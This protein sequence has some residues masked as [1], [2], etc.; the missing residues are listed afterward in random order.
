MPVDATLNSSSLL[1]FRS[2]IV[3]KAV[4]NKFGPQAPFTALGPLPSHSTFMPRIASVTISLIAIGGDRGA[5]LS[6]ASL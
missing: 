2:T 4:W 1:G 5:V 3:A 6:Q